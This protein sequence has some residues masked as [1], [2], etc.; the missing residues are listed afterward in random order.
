VFTLSLVGKG[1]RIEAEIGQE[2]HRLNKKYQVPQPDS[3]GRAGRQ[4]KPVWL[5]EATPA[6]PNNESLSVRRRAE[7]RS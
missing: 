7:G 5:K 4:G 1:K 6:M 2:N 3:G